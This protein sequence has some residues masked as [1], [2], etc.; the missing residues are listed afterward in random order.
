MSGSY[1]VVGAPGV[2]I[3]SGADAGRVYLYEINATAGAIE[4]VS[5]LTVG[6]FVELGSSIAVTAAGVV[7]AGALG[8]SGT[9]VSSRAA[10]G[11]V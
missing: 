4:L 3:V 9:E 11:R 10:N 2:D 8:Y 7:A 1:V 5:T 6:T